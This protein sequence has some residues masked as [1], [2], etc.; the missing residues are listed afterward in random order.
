MVSFRTSENHA[1]G[2]SEGR[3]AVPPK[4]RSEAKDRAPARLTA[5]TRG[6]RMQATVEVWTTLDPVHGFSFEIVSHGF[7]ALQ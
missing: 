7:T 6:G 3:G 2:V 4:G 5:S 1:P